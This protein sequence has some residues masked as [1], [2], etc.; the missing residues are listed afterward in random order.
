MVHTCQHV[1]GCGG[2]QWGGGRWCGGGWRED[3]WLPLADDLRPH[4]PRDLNLPSNHLILCSLHLKSSCTRHEFPTPTQVERLL[5]LSCPLIPD[6]H[7]APLG[8][9]ISSKLTSETQ[10]IGYSTKSD[11]LQGCC[12]WKQTMYT[13]ECIHMIWSAR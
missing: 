8:L 9:G 13:C 2:W 1:F 6:V 12:R 3:E 10:D 11:V 5:H 4:P 7:L